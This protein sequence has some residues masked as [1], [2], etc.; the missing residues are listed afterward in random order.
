MKTFVLLLAATASLVLQTTVTFHG[1][2]P[3]L[4]TLLAY[5]VGLS[6][7]AAKGTLFGS[8]LGTVEDSIGGGMIG[9][10]LLGK[11]IVGL[12]SSFLSGGP[13]QWSPLLGT[14]YAFVLTVMDG[15]V[16][17][18]VKGVY[19]TFPAPPARAALILALQGVLNA[20]AG[21]LIKPPGADSQVR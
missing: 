8:L 10:N 3:A 20:C 4:T 5:Y 12:F 13:F 19:E 9:P 18:I 14:V 17:F 11:G 1:L 16:V 7:G 21:A 6:S 15:A 2:S